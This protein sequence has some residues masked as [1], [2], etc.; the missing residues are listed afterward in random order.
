MI[1]IVKGSCIT[2]LCIYCI[3]NA[4]SKAK[5]YCNS[6]HMFPAL[7]LA[8]NYHAGKDHLS[9]MYH[10]VGKAALGLALPQTDGFV[11]YVLKN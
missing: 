1:T 9:T 11:E 7:L 10:A 8:N 6:V 3:K 4:N 5:Q 2:E